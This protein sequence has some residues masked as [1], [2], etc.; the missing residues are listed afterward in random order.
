[1]TATCSTACTNGSIPGGGGG[2]NGVR[3]SGSS[4]S[5]CNGAR[6]EVRVY[7]VK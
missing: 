5:G 3:T 6:G 1:V 7:Y 2:G 4:T